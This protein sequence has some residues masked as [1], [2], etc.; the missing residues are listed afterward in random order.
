MKLTTII[1]KGEPFSYN[2]EI[3]DISYETISP[4]SVDD[5]KA[6]LEKTQ[7]L[8]SQCGFDFTLIFGTLLGAV[9]DKT[10]IEGDEDVDVFV[11][12][13]EQLRDALPFLQQNGL[14]LC[15]ISEHEL[16]SFRIDNSTAYI[17][18]YIRQSIHGIWGSRYCVICSLPIPKK[19]VDNRIYLNFLGSNYQAPKHPERFIKFNYGKSWVTPIR[20]D[21]QHHN[22]TFYAVWK[23]THGKNKI[24]R[25]LRF[26]KRTIKILTKGNHLY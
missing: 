8:F 4:I 18:V 12:N 7:L 16:Y 19:L 21:H 25:I 22:T 23:N 9:R 3:E 11:D 2:D 6:L 26:I 5:A 24:I 10:I 14:Y 15:R 20:G 1:I 13:E 17:D